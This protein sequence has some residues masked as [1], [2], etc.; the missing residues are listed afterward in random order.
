MSQILPTKDNI[1]LTKAA[2]ERVLGYLTQE[3]DSLGLRFGVKKTGCNG[4][5]YVI[6]ITDEIA[7]NDTVFEDR[8]I[9]II[10]D[11]SS[12]EYL[13]G[14]EIDFVKQGLNEAFQFRNPKVK[15]ECGC[16]ESFSI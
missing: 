13:Q 9:K 16:G 5:A 3:K 4:Y 7:A 2:A 1:T 14:T 11:N 6:N 8:G 15:G 10:V 12:L